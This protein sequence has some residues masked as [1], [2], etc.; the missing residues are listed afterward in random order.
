MTH[1]TRA[2][3]LIVP[4]LLSVLLTGTAPVNSFEMPRLGLPK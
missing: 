3:A 1:S 2:K 4:V